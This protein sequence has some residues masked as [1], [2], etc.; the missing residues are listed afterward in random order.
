MDKSKVWV[1]DV[2]KGFILGRIVDLGSEAITVLPID[3]GLKEIRCAYDRVYPAEED[4]NKDVD[5]NCNHLLHI[6][7]L[8]S[9][10]SIVFIYQV[11]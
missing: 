11:P 2:H 10:F 3:P 7:F 9:V 8:S 4:D 1:P 6:S 5:D